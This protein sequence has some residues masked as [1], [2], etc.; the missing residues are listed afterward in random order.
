MD[1]LT[2]Q[3]LRSRRALLKVQVFDNDGKNL[4]SLLF[5]L[6]EAIPNPRPQDNPD[7]SYIILAT[8]R[9]LKATD[10]PSGRPAPSLRA[11]LVIEPN[12]SAEEV[13][14]DHTMADQEE[15]A[16]Q[17]VERPISRHKERISPVLNNEKGYFS[18]GA[19]NE[20]SHVFFFN[21]FICFARHVHLSFPKDDKPKPEVSFVYDLFG[22]R[23]S[24]KPF[25]WQNVDKFQ[26]ER[27]TAKIYTTPEKV[28][29]F[30][31][32]KMQSFCIFISSQDSYL[33]LAEVNLGK[34]LELN[35][36]DLLAGKL[37]V[38]EGILPLE[39]VK[40][41]PE[42]QD[43]STAKS[44]KSESAANEPHIGVRFSVGIHPDAGMQLVEPVKEPELSEDLTSKLW[45][46][47]PSRPETAKKSLDFSQIQDESKMDT[48]VE[49]DA[50]VKSKKLPSILDE[51]VQKYKFIV[52]LK[53]MRLFTDK[54]VDCVLKYKYKPFCGTEVT[55][56]PS[57]NLRPA[58]DQD[59]EIKRGYCEYNFSAK[60]SAVKK[61]LEK[62]PL[63]VRVFD[64]EDLLGTAS[65]NLGKLFT[66]EATRTL[67][68]RSCT[69]QA[70]ILARN[71]LGSANVIGHVECAFILKE[72]TKGALL[73][74]SSVSAFE[75]VVNDKNPDV[76]ALEIEEW[77]HKQKE[78]FKSQIQGLESH[79]ISVLTKEW[80]KREKEREN[81]IH[82]KMSEIINVEK[83][84]K[85]ALEENKAKQKL[86][87]AREG[88]L[89]AK[90]KKLN[91]REERLQNLIGSGKKPS[92]DK[93]QDKIK[94]LQKENEKLKQE[95]DQLKTKNDA[96]KNS[97]SELPSLK[98]EVATL[99]SQNVELAKK[100]TVN[101]E[102]LNQAEKS[103]EFYQKAFEEADSLAKK[104]QVEKEKSVIEKMEMITKENAKLRNDMEQS[105]EI[106]ERKLLKLAGTL[107]KE[108][109]P[110]SVMMEVDDDNE[111]TFSSTTPTTAI[112]T[113]KIKSEIMRLKKQRE[114]YL[115]TKV[116]NEN[117]EIIKLIDAKLSELT[118]N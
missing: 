19:E 2:F 113:K 45:V 58:L 51:P 47:F 57:F 107:S 61:P 35:T 105:R 24:S 98:K 7:E 101:L 40:Q 25:P 33:S 93:L 52:N 11:A 44:I 42:D 94:D 75:S 82:E 10:L 4:G 84:L 81:T 8:W 37:A 17:I 28:V 69:V 89:D 65:I 73:P 22:T 80:E 64:N 46:P 13:E 104:L 74:T 96:L 16:S 49:V 14:E 29:K 87:S 103:S 70:P 62:H 38:Y 99:R 59:Q 18:I 118:K 79:H 85:K 91:E 55:T 15:L 90:E 56:A 109:V 110:S 34:R 43:L 53:R 60:E 67:D 92:V 41:N 97:T 115:N 71:D 100:Q 112:D 27:A 106:Y 77:K 1:R 20:A 32:E 83:E 54:Y 26:S 88:E 68:S 3:A 95:V 48:S 72:M 23:I 9:K 36:D 21:I 86:L 117:D 39:T 12:S 78:K 116:Y 114:L 102:K 108:N 50:V 30:F 76:A 63:H 6:K 5:D 111:N 31:R 66:V